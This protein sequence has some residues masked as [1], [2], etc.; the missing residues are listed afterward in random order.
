MYQCLKIKKVVKQ[1]IS[2]VTHG[3]T[4]HL[5]TFLD[6]AAARVFTVYVPNVEVPPF[7]VGVSYDLHF[8]PSYDG[9]NFLNDEI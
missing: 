9:L 2:G 8:K 3:R 7:D 6:S 5:V 4:F 1:P